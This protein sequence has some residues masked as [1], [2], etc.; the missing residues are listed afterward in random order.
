MASPVRVV[1]GHGLAPGRATTAC[2]RALDVFHD[3]EAECSRFTPASDLSQV[4][5]AAD[6]WHR[7]GRYC[8]LAIE[9]AWQAYRWTRGRFDPRVLSD[10]ITLG[11]DQWPPRSV[12]GEPL[13]GI[14][15]AALRPARPRWRPRW[16]PRFVADTRHV[17]VDGTPV[18]LGGIGKGIAVRWASGSLGR[19]DHLVEAG[20]D[21]FCSGAAP[22][23]GPWRVGVEDPTGGDEPLAVLALSD[24]ACTTS[25]VRRR[26]WL[27]DGQ[28]VHHLIDPSTGRPGGTGL[29]SVTVIGTDPAV[30]EVWSK[31]LFLFGAA[32][33]D[34]AAE[35]Q[36][37]AACW[38]TDDGVLHVNSR[39]NGY[40]RWRR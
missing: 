5:S 28:P 7:V 34:E 33:V 4:N 27:S 38:V 32:A 39:A 30:A 22:D 11:Y 12:E 36:A 40:V 26:R 8:Y 29:L 9:E 16:R 18:D 35:R 24:R 14:G 15:P 21:C 13:G 37:L 23:G 17:H 31:V 25:S 1:L 19:S 3:V 10:L 20:G 2:E 6:R